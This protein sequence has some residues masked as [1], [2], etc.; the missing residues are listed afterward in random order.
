MR[1]KRNSISLY[2]TGGVGIVA[3]GETY[4]A[5]SRKS[6][7]KRETRAFLSDD[8]DDESGN[9]TFSHK[10]TASQAMPIKRTHSSEENP[11]SANNC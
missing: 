11:Y 5:S 3:V 2:A 6:I 8:E 9:N 4:K 10:P 1:P 7:E